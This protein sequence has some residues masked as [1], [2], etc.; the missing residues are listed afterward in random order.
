[1]SAQ[2][3]RALALQTRCDA[4]NR[5]GVDEARA[6]IRAAIDRIGAQI[7]AGKAF[8]GPDLHLVVLPEYVLT[9]FPQGDA[10]VA[11]AAKAAIAPDGAEYEAL[12]DVA[13]RHGIHLAGNAYEL[14]AHF[15]GLYFQCSFLVTPSGDIA[16]RYR[17]L[18]SMYS[19][20]PH[21]VWDR[22]LDLYGLDGVF[23]VADTALGR[24]GAVASEEILFPELARA[25]ALRGAEVLVHAT[26]EAGSP[27]LTPKDVARRARAH[28]NAVYVVSANSAGIFGTAMP[29]QSTDGM[30]KVVDYHGEVLCE[31][32]Y[33]ESMV[34]HAELDIEALRQW[35]RRPGMG[36]LLGRQR[37]ELF[38]DQ[39]AH[40]VHPPNSMLS[41]DGAVQVPE[42]SEFQK[43]HRR[44]IADLVRRGV[45]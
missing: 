13:Q 15:P 29:A 45:L 34:A 10:V 39:Y 18:I 43:Q 9:G 37:T 4:V 31:A 5:L 12:G 21:D 2:R 36:N 14:D 16:L 27:R 38:R 23:P 40:T 42:R 25:L 19:P 20:T 41:G 22:Y 32:G 26:S 35:R 30:S 8:I 17:R 1:M 6:Q 44:V 24:I 3:Y 7:G 11:W 33:G 28:E